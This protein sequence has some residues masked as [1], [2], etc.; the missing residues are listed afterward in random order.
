MHYKFKKLNFGLFVLN[1][2]DWIQIEIK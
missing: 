1:L 2:I